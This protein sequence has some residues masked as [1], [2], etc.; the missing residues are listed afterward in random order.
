L[1][2]LAAHLLPLGPKSWLLNEAAGAI[3]M[4]LFFT[5]S[6]FLITRLL[7]VNQQIPSFLTK[8]FLRIIPLAWVAMMAVLISVDTPVSVYLSHFLFYANLPVKS[9]IINT[10]HL[11]IKR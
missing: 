8:R 5:L 2:V 6:G 4:A 10:M 1:F 7:L 9:V 3:G 11:I